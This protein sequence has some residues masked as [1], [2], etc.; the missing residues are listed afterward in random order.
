VEYEKGDFVMV[1]IIPK[2]TT[3]SWI[4]PKYRKINLKLQPRYAGPYEIIKCVSPVVYVIKVEGIQRV[5][6]SINMKP[7]QGKKDALT[8]YVEP[9]YEKLDASLKKL[10]TPLLISPVPSLNEASRLRFR[11]KNTSE[12][13]RQTEVRNE[14]NER[15]RREE[16]AQ[17]HLS[18][19]ESQEM[20]VM[21]DE[22]GNGDEDDDTDDN[23]DDDEENGD[24]LHLSEFSSD[25]DDNDD[26]D[27][28]SED[29]C[30][31]DGFP[32][33][34]SQST[35][36]VKE[37]RSSSSSSSSA[38]SNSNVV[39]LSQEVAHLA[40]TT[41][42]EN[43]TTKVYRARVTITADEDEMVSVWEDK[44]RTLHFLSTRD[45]KFLFHAARI[46]P[47][48]LV[49]DPGRKLRIES[50]LRKLI[51][52]ERTRRSKLSRSRLDKEE[53]IASMSEIIGWELKRL[54][55]NWYA[56]EALNLDKQQ[57]PSYGRQRQ[58]SSGDGISIEELQGPHQQVIVEE[59]N[60]AQVEVIE[61]KAS[62]PAQIP[63]P[64]TPPMTENAEVDTSSPITIESERRRG[65]PVMTTAMPSGDRALILP[66]QHELAP[67]KRLTYVFFW[68][69]SEHAQR[70]FQLERPLSWD[71]ICSIRPKT[72]L[73][74]DECVP[75][76][77]E[78]RQLHYHL[79]YDI[80]RFPYNG[81]LAPAESTV[82]EDER[83]CN[84]HPEGITLVCSRVFHH[85]R[86]MTHGAR[87]EFFYPYKPPKC[88]SR[89]RPS[90]IRKV[91]SADRIRKNYDRWYWKLL[92]ACS[93]EM[94]C[95]V[96]QVHVVDMFRHSMM[97]YERCNV[98]SLN[99]H[100][101]WMHDTV[102]RNVLLTEVPTWVQETGTRC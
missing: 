79:M 90:V 102:N 98:H 84:H 15:A 25:D 8:P 23:E 45:C 77:I 39:D 69:M 99:A 26:D 27:D 65:K 5:V 55:Q 57:R 18:L 48:D 86:K 22:A 17:H 11:V 88:L 38:S 29:E 85:F 61:P 80:R 42:S 87:K 56:N 76:P 19:S 89:Q 72:Q 64:T 62:N 31:P 44:V 1:S 16:E 96:P 36:R 67:G 34:S 3:L 78:R 97:H 20:W 71:P 6:H 75:V 101:Y 54:D 9:G 10:P 7:F 37:P 28:E 49:N 66:I 35:E 43:T 92:M 41:P 40:D 58:L 91:I 83:F 12:K 73:D 32:Y 81:L 46:H 93:V 4:D 51:P 53:D 70:L 14:E 47:D 100:C 21:E 24:D 95:D 59:S 60:N 94:E 2:A 33:E 74:L 13:K 52:K 30:D 68:K 63:M 50:W 82:P